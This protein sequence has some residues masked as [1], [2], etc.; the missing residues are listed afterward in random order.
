MNAKPAPVPALPAFR[1][2]RHDEDF[3]SFNARLSQ[4]CQHGQVTSAEWVTAPGVHANTAAVVLKSGRGPALQVEVWPLDGRDRMGNE[5]GDVA[6]MLEKIINDAH[7]RLHAPVDF[8]LSPVGV[9][10]LSPLKAL[11]LPPAPAPLDPLPPESPGAPPFGFRRIN[12][13]TVEDPKTAPI[14]RRIYALEDAGEDAQT[15]AQIIVR[16]FPYIVERWPTVGI[17][18]RIVNRIINRRETDEPHLSPE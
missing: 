2:R 7:T 17:R 3:R 1:M 9:L 6:V 14:L 10:I 8:R 18:A 15:I 5:R 16:E 13:E 4:V 12:G 11:D